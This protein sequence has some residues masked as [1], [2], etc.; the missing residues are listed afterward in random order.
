MTSWELPQEPQSRVWTC[1]GIVRIN[2]VPYALTT[3]HP[4]VLQST[5]KDQVDIEETN[6]SASEFVLPAYNEIDSK[7][8]DRIDGPQNW[9]TLGQTTIK[10][11]RIT[12]GS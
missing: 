5:G 2:G 9:Q 4:W 3:A 1:G 10:F 12:T 6:T 11:L 8:N 7:A